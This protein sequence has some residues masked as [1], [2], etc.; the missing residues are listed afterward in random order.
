MIG[1]LFSNF[2]RWLV[3]PLCLI[4]LW[5]LSTMIFVSTNS[6]TTLTYNYGQKNF[7]QYTSDKLLKGEKIAAQFTATENNLGTVAVRFITF[8]RDNYDY[9]I[10][11]MKRLDTNN[12][13]Y[14]NRYKV[15]QFQPDQLFPFGFPIIPNSKGYTYYFEIESTQGIEDD[16]VAVSNKW[17]VFVANYQFSRNFLLTDKKTLLTFMGKKIVSVFST[18]EALA[19]SVIYLLPLVFYVF[20]ESKL[21]KMTL[22]PVLQLKFSFIRPN[23]PT[24][25]LTLLYLAIL[26]LSTL[27]ISF[28]LSSQMIILILWIV[29]IRKFRYQSKVSYFLALAFLLFT[30]FLL[31]IKSSKAAENA[32]ILAY[33]FMVVGAVQSAWEIIHQNRRRL[34]A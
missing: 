6:L 5:I 24:Y 14:E 22:S 11:R 16:S 4:A 29:L 30:L 12:W 8:N 32:A 13:Y 18:Q 26:I 23:I 7:I 19:G 33:I 25:S 2:I 15:D 17:P 31:I 27:I 10:F 9:L 21:K 28:N 3:I 1:L 34:K 20:L